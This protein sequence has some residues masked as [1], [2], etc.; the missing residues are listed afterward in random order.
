[1]GV[2]EQVMMGGL[3]CVPHRTLSVAPG[4]RLACVQGL[5]ALVCAAGQKTDAQPI[6]NGIWSGCTRL[7]SM[8][9]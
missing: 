7:S 6:P 9:V 3:L 1:M 2:Q 5:S 8:G 4:Q